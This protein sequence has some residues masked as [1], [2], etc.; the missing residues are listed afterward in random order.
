MRKQRRSAGALALAWLFSLAALA[1]GSAGAGCPAPGEWRTGQ[2][3][4]VPPDR[5]FQD[6]ARAEVVLLG[7][8]HDRMEHH[9]WQLHTLAGLHALRPA[10]VI[11]LEMLPREAQPALDAWVAGELDEREF[12]VQSQWNQ[13]WGF[14][15]ELY[16]PILHFARMHR[17]PLRGINVD[18]PLRQR[19]ISE[20]WEGVPTE[21]RHQI[22]PPAE[23]PEAYRDYLGQVLAEHPT[24]SD[25]ADGELDRFVSAQLIWDRAMAAGLAEAIADEVLV[26]GIMGSGHLQFGHGVPHQLRDLGI[27][28]P[29]TLLP[30]EVDADCR[31]PEP[32]IAHAVFGIAAADRHERPAPLML[33]VRIAP[34]PAGVQVES[35]LPDSVAAAAGLEPGDVLTQAAGQT[36]RQPQDLVAVVR[37][38]Q[39]GHVLPLNLLREEQPKEILA[40]F[41]FD[42]H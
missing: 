27:T 1:S 36:L 21:E 14:D 23:P 38:Q 20:G 26:V 35:V 13:S 10:L 42:P 29:L 28:D 2:G 5:L 41:P 25:D 34:H 30:W 33:G 8:R 4:P 24:R 31:V 12:L 40:R 32:G 19:L 3:E 16:L 22:S 17:L 18:Q 15:P 11:G 6:L 9:R 39:P 7:E 37:R